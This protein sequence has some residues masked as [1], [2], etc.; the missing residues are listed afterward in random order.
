[1]D[2]GN[3]INII[4]TIIAILGAGA[5]ALVVDILKTNNERLREANV[6]LRIRRE[7]EQRRTELALD[8]LKRLSPAAAGRVLAAAETTGYESPPAAAE[9]ILALSGAVSDESASTSAAEAPSPEPEQV[10]VTM[11]EARVLAR[12]FLAAKEHAS[13]GDLVAHPAAPNAPPPAETAVARQSHP[14]APQDRAADHTAPAPVTSTPES[15]PPRKNWDQLLK[16]GRRTTI[17]VTPV[18]AAVRPRG[19]LIPFESLQST[20]AAH[21]EMGLRLPS[22]FHGVGELNQLLEMTKPLH[23]LVVSI[24]LNVAPGADSTIPSGTLRGAAGECVRS[25]LQVGEF[26]CHSAIDQF[27]VISIGAPDVAQRRLAEINEKLWDFQTRSDSAAGM[28]LSWGVHEASGEPLADA[29]ASA[30]KKMDE[31]RRARNTGAP[32]QVGSGRRRAV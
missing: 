19:E 15:R 13:N 11:A 8:Q 25:M 27:L 24:A 18:P 29:I 7:E 14:P 22:G 26:G 2:S 1:M 28:A 4:I 16:G 12:E 3:F 32:P 20:Q 6:E 30:I 9:R 31:S 10:G 21:A 17:D 5:V 23:G